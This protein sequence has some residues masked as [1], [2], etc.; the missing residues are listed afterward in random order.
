[1]LGLLPSVVVKLRIQNPDVVCTRPEL[2]PMNVVLNRG[3]PVPVVV[4]GAP[5]HHE[6]MSRPRDR[7]SELVDVRTPV[8]IKPRDLRVPQSTVISSEGEVHRTLPDFEPL[9]DV[10]ET[11]D[12]ER[13]V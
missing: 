8:W 12:Q 9:H 2:D 1:E 6:V 5:K 11:R 10:V 13:P 3:K 7:S 4:N